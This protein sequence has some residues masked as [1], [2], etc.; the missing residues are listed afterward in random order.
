MEFSINMQDVIKMSLDT[1]NGNLNFHFLKR[2]LEAVVVHSG[3][4]RYE[5]NFIGQDALR[6][7]QVWAGGP[8][9]D[10]K[11]LTGEF[12]VRLDKMYQTE[13]GESDEML[14]TKFDNKMESYSIMFQEDDKIDLTGFDSNDNE[15]TLNLKVLKKI[16]KTA[17]D[18]LTRLENSSGLNYF[19]VM[20]SVVHYRLEIILK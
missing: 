12:S 16:E 13:E 4:N 18:R 1:V 2:L 15:G 7:Q 3:L 8:D 20:S 17:D 11:P 6:A 19:S 14:K 9:P 5:M 10:E